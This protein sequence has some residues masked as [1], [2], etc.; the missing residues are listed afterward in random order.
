MLT[1]WKISHQGP[2]IFWM[3][4]DACLWGPSTPQVAHQAWAKTSVLIVNP[5]VNA[6]AIQVRDQ[7]R[8]QTHRA[9]QQEFL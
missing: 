4:V 8:S 6:I 1:K 5:I 9:S 3:Q 7:I 2:P